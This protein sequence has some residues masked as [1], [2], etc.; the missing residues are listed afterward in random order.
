MIWA[1][2]VPLLI[3]AGLFGATLLLGHAARDARETTTTDTTVP[4]ADADATRAEG[5]RR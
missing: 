2:L 3:A 1:A 5:R 4:G